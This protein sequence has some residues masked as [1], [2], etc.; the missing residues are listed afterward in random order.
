ME[1]HLYSP[2][3]PAWCKQ[4]SCYLYGRSRLH[5]EE[6]YV[7][8]SSPNIFHV[9]KNEMDRACSTY[10]G[11]ERCIQGIRGKIWGKETTLEDPGL[12]RRIILKW[13]SEK[14]D[15]KAQTRSFWFWTGTGGW[16]LW[17]RWWTFGFHD[18]SWVDE[19]LLASQEGLCSTESVSQSVSQSVS[20]LY[21]DNTAPTVKT[22][23]PDSRKMNQIVGKKARTIHPSF[24]RHFFNIPVTVS[25]ACFDNQ[26]C[27]VYPQNF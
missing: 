1:L 6:L 16:L 14:W 20:H 15:M 26:Q 25:I 5:N 12:D 23:K 7:L 13:I 17:M 21:T 24:T 4:G 3:I 9:I 19:D 22:Y 18:I 11:E 27:D 8:Y 10:G 2:Y